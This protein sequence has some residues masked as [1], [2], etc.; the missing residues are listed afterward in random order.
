MKNRYGIVRDTL[1]RIAHAN[2]RC[3]RGA[4]RRMR[5]SKS[6]GGTAGDRRW[7]PDRPRCRSP[8]QSLWKAPRKCLSGVRR[9]AD[10]WLAR[11]QFDDFECRDLLHAGRSGYRCGRIALNLG[12]QAASNR[13]RNFGAARACAPIEGDA[14][15]AGLPGSGG[16]WLFRHQ[17]E[18]VGHLAEFG[19]RMGVHLPHRLAAVDLH[20]G[21]GNADTARNLLAQAI[22]RDLSD[23][24]TSTSSCDT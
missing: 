4:P 18:P 17:L 8:W 6:G 21:F 22:P 14:R 20:R 24:G 16:L 19:K 5:C 1:N 9:F 15:K 13:P 11:G 12:L 3:V 7:R 23:A 2:H 10:E